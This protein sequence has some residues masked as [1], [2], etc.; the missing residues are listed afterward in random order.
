MKYEKYLPLGSVIILKEQTAKIMITGYTV[1]S[2]E[3]EDKVYDYIGCLYPVGYMGNEKMV[4]FNHEDIGK[5]YCVGYS[6]DEDQGFK[7]ILK[8]IIEES[9]KE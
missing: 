8:E 1:M 4:L 6:D 5:V 3:G 9:N 2:N 7:E